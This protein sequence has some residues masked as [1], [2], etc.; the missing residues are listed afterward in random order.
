MAARPQTMTTVRVF[1]CL[2]WAEDHVSHEA[3]G[4]REAR[5]DVHRVSET[6]RITTANPADL[7]K[8]TCAA[9]TQL[10]ALAFVG[11]EI[12]NAKP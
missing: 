8:A 4:T 10:D 2:V 11:A 9:V 12:T 1:T 7:I 3:F 6:H 5:V